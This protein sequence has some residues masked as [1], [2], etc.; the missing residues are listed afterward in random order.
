MHVSEGTPTGNA[1]KIWITK[2]GKCYLC[3]NNSQ[4]PARILRNI[5]DIIEARSEEVIDKWG[6]YFGKIEYYC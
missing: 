2:A 3:H 6:N 1:A 5:M 4:I